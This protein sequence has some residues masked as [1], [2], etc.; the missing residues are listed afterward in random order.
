MSKGNM[1]LGHA[2]GKVGSLVFSRSNGQQIVRARAEVVKNPQTDAQMVQRI[3]LNTV[4]QAYSKMS[5][6]VDHSFEGISAGQKSMSYFM[7][8]NLQLLREDL[9]KNVSFED[10]PPYFS[11]V[12]SNLFAINTYEISKGSLPEVNPVDVVGRGIMTGI[13]T[14][15]YKGVLDAYGLQ[16]GDQLTI[17]IVDEDSANRHSFKYARVILDPR[18][19]DGSEAPLSTAFITNTAITKPNPKNETNGITFGLI[20][21]EINFGS[22]NDAA[23]GGLIASRQR[24]DGSWLRSNSKLQWGADTM[25][26]GYTMQA[27]LDDFK[28]GQIEVINPKY[29][30]NASKGGSVSSGSGVQTVTITVVSADSNM[31]TVSGGG[32]KRVGANVTVTATEQGT[33]VFN[34]WYNGNNHVSDA[35]PY[36]FTAAEDITLTARFRQGGP[37][38][39]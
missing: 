13:T 38:G 30:N 10:A 17:I 26:P 14:N 23:A 15:T 5:A 34:G 35:N 6:I 16:R 27:A 3:I 2:R 25:A 37:S 29:L 22:V 11:P 31:G 1:L 8:R 19:A 36:T 12:N 18:E 4:S 24:E 9:S 39:D 32:Q 28:A 33:N 21:N 20:D 7:K